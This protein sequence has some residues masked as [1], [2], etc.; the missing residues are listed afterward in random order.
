MTTPVPPW[1]GWVEF[2]A[3]SGAVTPPATNFIL[4][5]TGGFFILQEDGVSKLIQG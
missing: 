3:N 2:V 4:Q 1:M 5:E